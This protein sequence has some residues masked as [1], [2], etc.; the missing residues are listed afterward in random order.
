MGDGC[1]CITCAARLIAGEVEHSRTVALKPEQLAAGFV[2][3]CIAHPLS[4]CRLQ[5]GPESQWELY[6]NPWRPTI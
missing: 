3:L 4:D 1:A 5:V 6:R 2:L